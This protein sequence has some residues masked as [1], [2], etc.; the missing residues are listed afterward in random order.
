[1]EELEDWGWSGRDNERPKGGQALSYQYLTLDQNYH[2]TLV[3]F[4]FIQISSL[5]Q[6]L[7][8]KHLLIPDA[9]RSTAVFPYPL[10]NASVF[11]SWHRLFLYFHSWCTMILYFHHSWYT[12]LLWLIYSAPVFPLLKCNAPQFPQLMHSAPELIVDHFT[13]VFSW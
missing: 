3:A 9:V 13:A 7:H 2:N 10:D 4:V 1:M 11:H 12:L 5:K 8:A 6:H